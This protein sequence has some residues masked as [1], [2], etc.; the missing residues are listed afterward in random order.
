MTLDPFERR[1]GVRPELL[2]ESQVPGPVECLA[3]EDQPERGRVRRA[4]VPAERNLAGPRH[5]PIAYLVWDLARL[6][7]DRRI[8]GRRLEA[9][10]DAERID[11]EAGVH[12]QRT[13]Q[14]EDGIAAEERSEPRDAR[15]DETLACT[16]ARR[17]KEVEIGDPPGHDAVELRAVRADLRRPADACHRLERGGPDRHLGQDRPFQV[18]SSPGRDPRPPAGSHPADAR[19]GR[20]DPRAGR[21]HPRPELPPVEAQ[22][23]ERR[24]VA[25]HAGR[26]VVA[27]TRSDKS[28]DFED[29]GHVRIK[30]K[31][32]GGRR[33]VVRVVGDGQALMEATVQATLPDD[34]QRAGG[35]R[36]PGGSSRAVTRWQLGVGH[37]DR[38]VA[39]PVPVRPQG[40][41]PLAAHEQ[42][43]ARQHAGVADVHP[44]STLVG[45]DVT[46]L[47]GQQEDAAA[48]EDRGPAEVG[49][50]DDR[51][52]DV[53][54]MTSATCGLWHA[55]ECRRAA[56]RCH[57]GPLPVARRPDAGDR[58]GRI[59]PTQRDPTAGAARITSTAT[60]MEVPCR[61]SS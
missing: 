11:R 24:S 29:V 47:V 43:E 2:H 58:D 17:E 22:V 10:E 21:H 34:S 56:G 27:A 14:R 49:G 4:V 16:R 45:H 60:P 23:L 31:V 28:T 36:L 18:R 20:S 51:R 44:E 61:S 48:L 59:P 19:R 26:P 15:R 57:R 42:G 54:H 7:V 40:A 13:E 9:R 53:D 52:R 1:Q 41:R 8:V 46:E 38:A 12:D 33:W 39:R 32:H 3:E 55:A 30:D 37:H 50:R 25:V 35:Q 5:L 6:R